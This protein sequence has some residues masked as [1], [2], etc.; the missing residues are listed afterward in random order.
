MSDE[1]DDQVGAEF[2]VNGV[3]Y[4]MGKLCDSR[5]T[6]C[7]FCGAPGPCHFMHWTAMMFDGV[8]Y[9]PRFFPMCGECDKRPK[10]ILDAII[11]NGG[12]MAD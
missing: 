12:K 5:V 9:S 8:V 3:R 6:P 4:R 2:V 11:A 10:H 1:F 7:Y